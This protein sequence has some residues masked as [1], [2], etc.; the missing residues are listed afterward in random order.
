MYD[1]LDGNYAKK[2]KMVTKFGD[3]Y[4]HIKDISVNILLVFVFYK[5]MTF[6]HNKRLCLIL[7]IITIILFTT[8]N[9][10]WVP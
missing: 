2:Y 9:I 3:L 10:H 5:Y 8:F 7:L 1:V 4:D 6:K